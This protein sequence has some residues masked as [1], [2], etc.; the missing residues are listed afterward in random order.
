MCVH[1]VERE[2]HPAHWCAISNGIFNGLAQDLWRHQW[3]T[4]NEIMSSLTSWIQ[5]FNSLVWFVS[6]KCWAPVLFPGSLWIFK[7]YLKSWQSWIPAVKYIQY[8]SLE[9]SVI[10]SIGRS[11]KKTSK[12]KRIILCLKEF[13]SKSC[14]SP[15]MLPQ[16]SCANKWRNM[17]QI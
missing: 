1:N 11:K 8:V 7:W 10:H 4:A 5:T 12:N 3:N 14:C 6:Y 16:H 13:T 9:F 2:K 17:P 15:Y